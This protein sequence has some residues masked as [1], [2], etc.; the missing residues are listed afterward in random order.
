MAS[1][2]VLNL[3][4]TLAGDADEKVR[5]LAEQVGGLGPIAAGAGLAI[6]GAL[7]AGLGKGY[8]LASEAREGVNQL[9]AQLGLTRE[10]AEQL[11]DVG[12]KVFG[13]N[14]YGS[15][16]EATAAVGTM[17]QTLGG[18]A[19]VSDAELKGAAES[20]AALK[21]VFGVEVPES[22]DAAATLMHEF[23]L[24][25]KEAFDFLAKG[26]QS[27]LDRSGDFLDSIGEYSVQFSG[28]GHD[29]GE[30][31]SILE[32]GAAGG[33]LGTDKIADAFKESRIRIMEMSDGVVDAFSTVGASAF[34]VSSGISEDFATPGQTLDWL[35]G[36][37]SELGVEVDTNLASMVQ[38]G[39]LKAGQAFSSLLANRIEDGTLSVADAQ[40]TLIDGLRG[41]DN[42]VSQ[43]AA[44]IAIFGTQWE[45]A[46][47]SA[48]LGVD[49]TKT[50]LADLN[51]A[52][53]SLNAK[54]SNFGSLFSGAWRMIQTEVLLPV[55]A[56]L[57]GLANS[58]MPLVQTA[59]T[60]LGDAIQFVKDNSEVMG[61]ILSGVAVVIGGLLVA[62]FYSWAASAWAAA[63]GTIAAMLPIMP[64][65]LAVAG[66]V[67]LLGVA[68]NQNWGGIQEKTAAV[69]GFLSGTVWPWLEGAFA[70]ITTTLLPA[71]ST[72]W[73]TVWPA[74]QSATATVY[75]FLKDTVWAW[76]SGTAWPW[77]ID[78]ALPALQAAW[79]T[80]WPIVQ[81]AVS[82]VY[83]FLS[84]TMWPWLET[85]FVNVVTWLG[86]MQTGWE[87]KFNYINNN[88]VVPVT[89]AILTVVSAF[90]E[91]PSGLLKLFF[92]GLESLQAQAEVQL[93][94]LRGMIFD[95]KLGTVLK[96]AQGY[97]QQI[98]GLFTTGWE[99]VQNTVS[100][101]W[102]TIGGYISGPIETAQGIIDRVIGGIKSTIQGA[103]DL[104]NDL[105]S[106][107][108]SIPAVPN[109][110]SVP[111]FATGVSNFS[112]GLAYV[113]A[114]EMLANLAPGTDVYTARETRS[115]LGGGQPLYITIDAR[116]NSNERA[117]EDAGYRGAKRAL[118]E[119]G[120]RAEDLQ[121]VRR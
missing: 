14:W 21:D 47:A 84:G 42:Q 8:A 52:T 57:L 17:K 60:G 55:G 62:A 101:I 117:V 74:I 96:T 73:N 80:V 109:L 72:A 34:R 120:Y 40:A 118:K 94:W 39:S 4:I 105:I 79:Q 45:D 32:T 81:G 82:T 121:R 51:G 35:K 88:I 22:A 13:G 41:V 43:N 97:V 20:A 106:A 28:A 115:L 116:G 95:S 5:G 119:A 26:Y 78:T 31:F 69:W 16:E 15:I 113:H 104:A 33:V 9:E 67:V 102:S 36:K 66:V 3:L 87:E 50:S 24:S 6:G 93:E 108:N 19:E 76:L 91:G 49:A 53:D 114:G 89:N 92:R 54:Y 58:T 37:A 100:G 29:A 112:G 56:W 98:A 65:I 25:S 18:V 85:A 64:I 30:F 107:I 75:S 10:E 59:I 70:L 2:A 68:W 86:T 103:I 12:V 48:I 111:S 38:S 44:G 27:G 61:P 46:G 1:E 11:G 77:I 7:V 83:T 23:G 99:G 110:P 90:M 71:L 63:A